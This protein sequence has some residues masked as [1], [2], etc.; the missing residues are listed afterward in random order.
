MS[1]DSIA[2]LSD[3]CLER[4]LWYDEDAA[5]ALFLTGSKSMHELLSRTFIEFVDVDFRGHTSNNAILAC[6]KKLR[7]LYIPNPLTE[8]DIVYFSH[9][10]VLELVMNTAGSDGV[11][12]WSPRRYFPSLTHL[13]L[14]LAHKP[15]LEALLAQELPESLTSLG[16]LNCIYVQPQLLPFPSS[17][18]KLTLSVL[19]VSDWEKEGTNLHQVINNLS[20]VQCPS[21]AYLSLQLGLD[22]SLENHARVSLES[23]CLETLKL[24]FIFLHDFEFLEFDDLDETDEVDDFD[25][26]YNYH[27]DDGILEEN[28]LEENGV[29]NNE[30]AEEGNADNG[31][32]NDLDSELRRKIVKM[33][34]VGPNAHLFAESTDQ[35]G[36]KS[37]HINVSFLNLIATFPKGLTSLKIIGASVSSMKRHN[38]SEWPD[39][40]VSLVVRGVTVIGPDIFALL[41]SGLV[42]LELPYRHIDWTH[43]PAGLERLVSDPTS[44]FIPRTLP[45]PPLLGLPPSLTVLDCPQL[46][47]DKK[48]IPFLPPNLRLLRYGQRDDRC[49]SE[50]TV[51]ALLPRTRVIAVNVNTLW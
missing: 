49:P 5:E 23:R 17:L 34:P 2:C 20:V 24:K 37:L 15:G 51:E 7:R 38:I 35:C 6:F 18:T 26:E 4:I 39:T 47:L 28:E 48:T 1:V 9:P 30:D 31:E 46:L 33:P 22:R 50:K 8:A 40:L 16:L 45:V 14:Q 42:T 41:P 10:G 21:L 44:R 25:D 3:E 36:L 11:I 13:S 43:L 19:R 27:P 32:E 12:T 29:D